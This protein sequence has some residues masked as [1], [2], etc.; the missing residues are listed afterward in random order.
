MMKNSKLIA[1]ARRARKAR[2]IQRRLN[3]VRLQVFRSNNHIY[4]Q[5]IV[6]GIC[7]T[8]AAAAS[9]V[10]PEIRKQ[11]KHTGNVE[12]AK[13]VGSAIAKAAQE[14]GITKVAFDR[15]GFAYHG[16]VKALAEEARAS[17]LLF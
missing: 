14:A 13:L 3:A 12:A 8:V 11:V 10:M 9:T 1:R 4:A 6:P 15:S 2:G 17:G 16:A 7:D 5:I